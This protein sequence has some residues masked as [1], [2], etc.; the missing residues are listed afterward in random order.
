MGFG[1][2]RLGRVADGSLLGRNFVTACCQ[3]VGLA[4]A[5]GFPDPAQRFDGRCPDKAPISPAECYT[6]RMSS[7]TEYDHILQLVTS[8]PADQRRS[9]AQE[10]LASVQGGTPRRKPPRN[11]ADRALGLARGQGPPPDDEEVARILDEAR[12]EKYGR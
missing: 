7:A 5:S 3:F 8:W 4:S 2:N 11:T 12:M 9:L 1:K 6:S 10:I